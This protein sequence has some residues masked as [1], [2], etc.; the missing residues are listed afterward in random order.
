MTE[1]TV[2]DE[3]VDKYGI[4]A[5]EAKQAYEAHVAKNAESLAYESGRLAADD[6]YARRHGLDA[7]PF[8]PVDHPEQRAAWLKGLRDALE[9]QPSV[10]SLREAVTQETEN[11]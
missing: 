11:A 5:D 8:S 10:E 2:T 4:T 6:S 9:D 1:P 7:C 3:H